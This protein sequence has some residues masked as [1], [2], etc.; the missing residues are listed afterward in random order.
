MQSHPAGE[1]TWAG[2]RAQPRVAI[3]IPVYRHSVLLSEAIESALAQQAG[4]AIHVVIVNDGCP[5]A[6]TEA[7]CTD[8]ALSYP[9]RITYLRKSNGGLSSARN[10]G[11]GYAMRKWPLLQAVY[12]L[13]ADNRLRAIAIAKAI[14]L[15]DATGCD[16][17]YPSLDMFGLRHTADFGGAYSNLV[18]TAMNTC[19]AGSLIN[20]RVFDA[21]VQFD[22]GMRLG[23]EDWDFFLSAGSRGFTGQEPG[24]LR[25]PVPQAAR[26]HA[27]GFRQGPGR[28][29]VGHVAQ[30]QR[31]WSTR[32]TWSAWSRLEAPRYAIYLADEKKYLLTV[33]PLQQPGQVMT[34][35]RV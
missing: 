9:Q 22:E 32:K 6:E 5:H 17:V 14:A 21:G 3:V 33:D 28:N 13:D 18:Q 16:W 29:Q 15:M 8:Y 31:T 25:V 24:R 4:F 1:A 20:R 19:E 34:P 23:F 10:H 35:T 12:L 2:A 26:K 27:G 7:V 11:I 30:A